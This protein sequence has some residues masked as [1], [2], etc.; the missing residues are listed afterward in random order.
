[1]NIRL[2]K[3]H[4]AIFG[5]DM[6]SLAKAMGFHNKSLYYKLSP[7]N[8]RGFTQSEIKFIVDRYK[9]SPDDVVKIFFTEQKEVE[10]N[11]SH[12]S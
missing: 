9:L 2:L 12:H 5:D 6:D 8:P 7:Q 10:L 4:M 11:D 3:G 1:M